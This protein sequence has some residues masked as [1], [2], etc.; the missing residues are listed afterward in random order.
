MRYFVNLSLLFFTGFTSYVQPVH[1]ATLNPNFIEQYDE[2]SLEIIHSSLDAFKSYFDRVKEDR[3]TLLNAIQV[4]KINPTP[5][6]DAQVIVNTYRMLDTTLVLIKKGSESIDRAIPELQK[7]RKY[8]LKV[9]V[10]MEGDENDL[11]SKCA[12][13]VEKEARNIKRLLIDLAKAEKEMKLIKNDLV[14]LVTTIL[15]RGRIQHERLQRLDKVL[16]KH[17]LDEILRCELI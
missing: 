9:S 16:R 17:C 11:L 14:M 7:Y 8:L 3:V 12:K 4:N 2:R 13:Q 1:A 10:S 5:E 15:R 6:N